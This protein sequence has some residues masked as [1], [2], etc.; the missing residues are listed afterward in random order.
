M[1]HALNSG[2]SVIVC[3]IFWQVEEEVE[4]AHTYRYGKVNVGPPMEGGYECETLS[5]GIDQNIFQGAE[6]KAQPASVS[7]KCAVFDERM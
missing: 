6:S 5:A 1:V 7:M 3:I 2:L 4:G